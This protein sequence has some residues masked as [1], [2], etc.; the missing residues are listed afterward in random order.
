MQDTG[1]STISIVVNG[2]ERTVR[3]G[4]TVTDLIRVLELDPERLAI[5]LDRSIV[6]RAQWPTTTLRAG[7]KIE[8]VQFVGGG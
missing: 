2:E 7:A 1:T 6:K 8:I 3:A 4:E 5:E